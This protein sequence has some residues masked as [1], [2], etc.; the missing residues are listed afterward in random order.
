ML[1]P[2]RRNMRVHHHAADRVLN[3]V[4]GSRARRMHL[5]GRV[6]RIIQRPMTGRTL[7]MTGVW[8]GSTMS[9]REFLDRFGPTRAA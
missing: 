8:L 4:F 9:H 6:E 1:R 7:A 2:E 5:Q 3:V